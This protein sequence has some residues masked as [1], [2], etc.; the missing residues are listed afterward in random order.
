MDHYCW[1]VKAM[2]PNC[3]FWLTGNELLSF[4][5]EETTA[6]SRVGTLPTTH[7]G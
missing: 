2:L 3:D 6:G 4:F 1:V 5:N 7:N